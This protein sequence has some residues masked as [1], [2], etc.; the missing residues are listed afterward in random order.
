MRADQHETAPR[1]WDVGF[2]VPAELDQLTM[3]HALAEAVLLVGGF[4]L[5]EA[6][7][8]LL[9]LDELVTAL[10]LE[11]VPDSAVECAFTGADGALGARVTTVARHPHSID[12]NTFGWHVAATLTDALRID[13]AAFDPVR[14]GYPTTVEFGWIRRFGGP[15]ASGRYA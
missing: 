12:E 13:Y 2:R 4:A 8:L 3:A 1:R 10:I 9:A 5:D 14:R 6:T 11:A 15:A 7:D